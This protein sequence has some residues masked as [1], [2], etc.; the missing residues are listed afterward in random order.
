MWQPPVHSRYYH[1][2]IH[3]KEGTVAIE[4]YQHTTKIIRLRNTGHS[5]ETWLYEMEATHDPWA[6][7]RHGF[8]A[9]QC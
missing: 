9:K 5:Y 2:Y 7:C 4:I 6:I 1:R 8:S 3:D